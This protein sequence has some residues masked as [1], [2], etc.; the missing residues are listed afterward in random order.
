VR[1]FDH[2]EH[3]PEKHGPVLTVFRS[4]LRPDAVDDYGATAQRMLELARTM[5]GFVDFKTFEA[6]D[7][8]RVSLIAFESLDAQR[9][10]REHPEHRQAQ[11]LGRVRFYSSYSIAVCRVIGRSEFNL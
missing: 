6:P 3:D 11:T 7:G 2:G 4:R 8:E 5:P 10:W 9:A 1:A